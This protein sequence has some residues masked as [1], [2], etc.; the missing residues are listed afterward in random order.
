M[1]LRLFSKPPVFGR[2]AVF[3]VSLQAI[4]GTMAVMTAHYLP[5]LLLRMEM[6]DR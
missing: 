2:R 6:C 3:S 1:K 5:V 4:K